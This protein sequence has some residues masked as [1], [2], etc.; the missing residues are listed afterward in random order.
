MKSEAG[1][2]VE[3]GKARRRRRSGEQIVKPGL[4]TNG[5]EQNR[6]S[7]ACTSPD[8][9]HGIAGAPECSYYLVKNISLFFGE[10]LQSLRNNANVIHSIV[11]KLRLAGT[12]EIGII[13]GESIR[14]SNA[15]LLQGLASFRDEIL[16]KCCG[17]LART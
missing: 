12:L 3:S 9:E 6:F 5:V 13:K 15:K 2:L 11:E 16:L 1:I 8:V 10:N 4:C 7:S 17:G 14:D